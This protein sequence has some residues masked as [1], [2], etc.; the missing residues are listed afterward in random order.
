MIKYDGY[1]WRCN[2]PFAE[3]SKHAT[4]K[5]IEPSAWLATP[6]TSFVDGRCQ[7]APLFTEGF[8]QMDFIFLLEKMSATKTTF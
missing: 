4:H 8:E 5:N 1:F 3:P 2:T 6:D 7:Y